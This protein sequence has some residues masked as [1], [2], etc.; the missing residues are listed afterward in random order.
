MVMAEAEGF[1]A[2][3]RF[4]G[5]KAAEHWH[6][7]VSM[8]YPCLQH[9]DMLGQVSALVQRSMANRLLQVSLL[10]A[11]EFCSGK[12]E[13]TKAFIRHQL[14]TACFDLLYRPEHDM[15]SQAGV[16][17]FLDAVAA[18]RR[19][20]LN[21]WG[22]TCSSFV[23]LCVAVSQRFAWND[24]LGNTQRPFVEEGNC[25]VEVMSLAMFVALLTDVFCILE[26][27]CNSVMP[28]VGSLKR[29]LEYFGMEK[30]QTWHGAFGGPSPK[31]LQLWHAKGLNLQSLRRDKPS[32]LS[33]DLVSH[34][35]GGSYT[36]IKPNLVQSAHYTRE[37]REAVATCFDLTVL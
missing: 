19:K 3:D 13:L 5:G 11:V 22:T 20:G 28:K 17:L 2:Y 34:G 24:F 35:D 18:T 8:A 25:Q 10:D 37:F 21:W 9:L 31:P 27:P 16:R 4:T 23:S 12:A 36:G 1:F 30:L 14:R 7:L 15:L 29:V 32:H 6:G 26:Q 33:S